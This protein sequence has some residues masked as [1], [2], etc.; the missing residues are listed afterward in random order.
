MIFLYIYVGYVLIIIFLLLLLLIV[1]IY[2]TISNYRKL[3]EKIKNEDYSGIRTLIYNLKS[4]KWLMS[5]KRYSKIL[6]IE[7]SL[8]D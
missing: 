5:S 6:E 8:Q 2:C 1:K 3:R 4:S 7:K